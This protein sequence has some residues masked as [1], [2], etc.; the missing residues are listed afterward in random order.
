MNIISRIRQYL[1]S[2]N[3]MDFVWQKGVLYAVTTLLVILAVVY[4]LKTPIHEPGDGDENIET[5]SVTR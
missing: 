4:A 5:Q 3:M 1:H 2:S